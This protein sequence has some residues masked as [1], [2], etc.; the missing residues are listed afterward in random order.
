MVREIVVE[1][2]DLEMVPK[3]ESLVR[4]LKLW[5]VQ[6]SRRGDLEDGSRAG[7]WKMPFAEVF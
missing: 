5:Y 3:L 4:S 7:S 2:M 1:L 6:G